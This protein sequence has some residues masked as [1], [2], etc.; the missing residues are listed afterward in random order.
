M[1][2]AQGSYTGRLHS[3]DRPFYFLSGSPLH[4]SHSWNHYNSC[5]LSF[6]QEK[7]T[8]ALEAEQQLTAKRFSRVFKAKA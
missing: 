4:L 5:R 1:Q 6:A 2:Q 8:F 3:L 7:L